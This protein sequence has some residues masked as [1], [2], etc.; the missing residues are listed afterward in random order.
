M[1]G[2]TPG[3]LCSPDTLSTGNAVTQCWCPLSSYSVPMSRWDHSCHGYPRTCYIKSH[4]P[5]SSRGY[6]NSTRSRSSSWSC[7]GHCRGS[8]NVAVYIGQTLTGGTT[9]TNMS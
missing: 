2:P 6:S 5:P 3:A 1:K 7:N 4:S 8:T 9:C